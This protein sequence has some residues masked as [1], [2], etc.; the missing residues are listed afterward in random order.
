MKTAIALSLCLALFVAPSAQASTL[1]CDSSVV[2]GLGENTTKVIAVKAQ[3]STVSTDGQRFQA[4]YGGLIITSPNMND[5][6][7]G[8]KRGFS[9]GVV[10]IMRQGTYQASNDGNKWL[11]FNHCTKAN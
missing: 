4:V 2:A 9:N 11:I 3:S 7:R 10:Y 6:G 8:V 5:V 1:I